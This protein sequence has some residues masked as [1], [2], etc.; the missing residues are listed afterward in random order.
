MRS[1]PA[2]ALRLAAVGF[3]AALACGPL[4]RAVE[5]GCTA[6]HLELD[7]PLAEPARLFPDDVHAA[8]GL[9]CHDCHGGDPGTMDMEAAMSPQK[10]FKAAPRDG[11]EVVA[12]CASCHSDPVYMRRFAPSLRI[13]QMAEYRSSVHGKRLFGSGDPNVATCVSC[14]GVHD[15]RAVSSPQARVYP[16]RIAETCA[17]CHADAARMK[18][19]GR[20]TDQYE[21]YRRSV[22]AD[23][24]YRQRDVSAPTCN[25][26]HGNHGASPPGGGAVVNVCGQC[27]TFFKQYFLESPHREPFE[28]IGQCIHCHGNHDVESPTDEWI[29][30]GSRA[31]C[32]QCHSSGDAG[33]AAAELIHGRIVT[34]NEAVERAAGLL[35]RAEQAGMEVAEP[36][37]ELRDA[38]QSLVKAR[39]LIH[40]LNPARVAERVDEGLAVAVKV[41]RAGLDA[42]A[43]LAFRRRGLLLFLV[44]ILGL[45][46]GLIWKIRE[47]RRTR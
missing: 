28:S 18:P 7:G 9:S 24:L 30:T 8:R 20:A 5:N 32:V 16:T 22:H 17:A 6:C 44:L 36:R 43:E 34:L 39:S 29:G 13:D 12:L 38:N 11:R 2:T 31:V 45:M 46:A 47:R 15:I 27:H 4:V 10:G 21:K 26:C 37:F 1:A 19:Y 40:T 33:Y 41:E 35:D 3:G 42:L 23:L 25:D 14:H